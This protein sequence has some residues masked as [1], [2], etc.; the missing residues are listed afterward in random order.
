MN[1]QWWTKIDAEHFGN[2]LHICVFWQ[3]PVTIILP[4]G[5]ADTENNRFI[6]KLHC[7]KVELSYQA[8]S[9]IQGSVSQLLLLGWWR[10]VLFNQGD[11]DVC[12]L[13][14]CT[15]AAVNTQSAATES[16]QRK[17]CRSDL[18]LTLV[19][20]FPLCSGLCEAEITNKRHLPV[21]NRG[22]EL[23]CRFYSVCI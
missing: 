5:T 4:S 3:Q 6:F 14:H 22:Q 17:S 11:A 10:G 18:D 16:H 12:H 15:P 19:H 9:Q 23:V 13:I 7:V 21:S 2:E 20:R 1:D 8:E